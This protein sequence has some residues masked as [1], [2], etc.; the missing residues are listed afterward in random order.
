MFFVS[1]LNARAAELTPAELKKQIDAKSEEIKKLEKT[2]KKYQ[3]QIVSKQETGKT[4]KSELKKI[5]KSI[6]G[7]KNDITINQRKIQ[8]TALEMKQLGTQIQEK[9]TTI[10]TLQRGLLDLLRKFY[11][12]EKEPPV[13]TLLKQKTLGEFF[14]EL[15]YSKLMQAKIVSSLGDLHALRAELGAEKT[16]V[17]EKKNELQGLQYSLKDRKQIQEVVKS[18]RSQLLAETKNQEKKY[19]ELLDVTEKRQEEIA[20]EIEEL[21]ATLRRGIDVHTLPLAKKGVLLWPAVGR[22]SQG[23]GETQFAHSSHFYKFHN[24]IDVAGAMGAPIV[25]ADDGTVLATG[26]SDLYCRR[27][28]YGKYIVIKHG[29]NLT[30]MYAHLSLIRVEEGQILKRGELIGYMGTTGR[31]TGPHLHFTVYDSRTV[32]IRLGSVGTCGL[33]PFGGSINPLSYLG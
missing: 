18:Y 6:A 5:E 29:S 10:G 20:K 24:G 33:L 31:S 17:Q 7:L 19:Q 2:A 30:S 27:G 13:I 3:D 28:S 1:F 4:L 25:A 12:K 15:D 8:K 14:Q 9:E 32:E 11:E 23:Y 22:L 16:R 21:E 26:N